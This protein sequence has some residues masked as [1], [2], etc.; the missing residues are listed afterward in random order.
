MKSIF[1]LIIFITIHI[2][3]L[4]SELCKKS[5]KYKKIQGTCLMFPTLEFNFIDNSDVNKI[6]TSVELPI[7]NK[8]LPN[9][10]F[11]FQ[12]YFN[13]IMP[14]IGYGSA[15]NILNNNTLHIRYTSFTINLGYDLLNS[16]RYWLYPYIGYKY[17]KTN[18]LY[19]QKNENET[20]EDYLTTNLISKE[21]SNSRSHI[22]IGLGT[23][24]QKILG[25]NLRV[26]YLVPIEKVYWKTNN[27]MTK[28]KEVPNFKYKFYFII[29][30]S[31]GETTK[32]HF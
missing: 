30:I 2:Q 12:L 31:I 6:L 24:I 32:D 16:H 10:G 29:A 4:G 8:W 11:T 7:I 9:Y 1:V 27:N 18:Y 13:R 15:T 5:E 26:G 25:A 20:F 28:L 14:T 21:L 23:S 17:C 19:N 3:T 22:D